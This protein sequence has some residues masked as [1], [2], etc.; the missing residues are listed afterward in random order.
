[1]RSPMQNLPAQQVQPGIWLNLSTIL[2]LPLSPR[3]HAVVLREILL[4][5]PFDDSPQHF[6]A[7]TQLTQALTQLELAWAMDLCRQGQ[8][9]EGLSRLEGL[10][11]RCDFEGTIGP[12]ILELL[13]EL[14]HQLVDL[15]EQSPSRCPFD[16][17]ERAELLW[18]C[19]NWLLRLNGCGLEQ[20]ERMAAIH[21]QIYRYGA[22]AWMPMGSPLANRR[23][24]DLLLALSEVNPAALAW[25]KPACMD[26]LEQEIAAVEQMI[27]LA[28]PTAELL[29]HLNGLIRVGQRFQNVF[30]VQED[31][32]N[33]TVVH[34]LLDANACLEVWV[35]LKPA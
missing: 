25:T 27:T 12:A 24:L 33:R 30:Q 28:Q 8:W 14:H 19:H 18:S 17:E 31:E 26:R 2:N 5:P 21:E 15:A 3:E 34:W 4:Q 20:S 16:E 29:N 22:L 10:Q 6:Q 7:K 23:S 11:E 9:S 13:P 35:Q 1:M 32:P